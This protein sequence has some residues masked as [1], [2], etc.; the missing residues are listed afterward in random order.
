MDSKT[1]ALFV[2]AHEF[3]IFLSPYCP[4]RKLH[5]VSRFALIRRNS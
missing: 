1:A 3:D 5:E 2:F 4:V